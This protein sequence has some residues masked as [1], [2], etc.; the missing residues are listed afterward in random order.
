[1]AWE[2]FGANEVND[3]DN[4]T[5]QQKEREWTEG[6]REK[7]KTHVFGLGKRANLRTDADI[8]VLK[9][10]IRAAASKYGHLDVRGFFSKIDIDGGG[11]LTVDE[12][13]R[14]CKR[15]VAGNVEDEDMR[16][17]LSKIDVD[18]SGEISI[19]EFAEFIG[20]S[21]ADDPGSPAGGSPRKQPKHKVISARA[22]KLGQKVSCCCL[23]LSAALTT[24]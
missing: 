10:K 12:L 2:S 4:R 18:N 24:H 13:L 1:M 3:F 21:L 6:I 14:G 19:G 7:G 16:S 9:S 8:A 20:A 23:L 15:L 11:T 17:L 22:L 5:Q